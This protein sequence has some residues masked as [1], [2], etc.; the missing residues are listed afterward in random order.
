MYNNIDLVHTVAGWTDELDEVEMRICVLAVK[1]AFVG[2]NGPGIY[3]GRCLLSE[4]F[5]WTGEDLGFAGVAALN[6]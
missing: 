6:L 3:N 4:Y 5:A 2:G 1:H